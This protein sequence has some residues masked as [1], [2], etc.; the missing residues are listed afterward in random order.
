MMVMNCIFA[1]VEAEAEAGIW[2]GYGM[3]CED[4]VNVE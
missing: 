1:D 2:N 4:E 3:Q